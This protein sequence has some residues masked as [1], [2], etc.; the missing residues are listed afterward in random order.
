MSRARPRALILRAPGVNCERET[1]HAFTLAGADCE[2]IHVKRLRA[3]PDLLDR[4]GIFVAPGGFSYGDDVAAGLVLATELRRSLGERL[5]AFVER[6]GLV[7]GICN[8]FQVLVRLGML[9]R[10]GG[11]ALA[12]Q[13]SLAH[14]LSA[15]YECRWV[16]LVVES[17]R[18][19]FLEPG[20]ILR[21]PAAHAEGRFAPRDD[22]HARTLL[23]EG[24]VALRY[25]D[26]QGR[27]TI[28][29]PA[30][31][32]G[33]PYGIAGLTDGS[34]RVLGLMPHPDRAYLPFHDP[35]WR[36]SSRRREGDGMRLFRA[37]VERA[38]R[39]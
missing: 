24:Y 14:N 39:A 22:N 2:L 33:S 37:I 1:A 27:P 4:F 19:E 35:A 13:V 23:E 12:Q 8:G 29:Y 28:E 9:P 25:A 5:A 3:N 17:T 20:Q 30:N 18:C 26:E 15:H 11:G 32:N 31:P 21:M 10:P 34:G 16:S 38:R 6:G 7:L 36:R